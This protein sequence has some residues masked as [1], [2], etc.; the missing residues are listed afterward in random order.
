MAT[1]TA[2]TKGVGETDFATLD[3]EQ[4]GE[5]YLGAPETFSEPQ[6][7]GPVIERE[8]V[9]PEPAIIAAPEG[10]VVL[11]NIKHVNETLFIPVDG[12]ITAG[13]KVQFTDGTA[14]VSRE[15]AEFVKATL[16][17]VREEPTEGE[18]WD[19]QGFQT[20][21]RDIYEQYVRDYYEN[22]QG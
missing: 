9:S 2:R 21:S 11:R 20:R 10:K 13:N 14:I 17:H 3:D 1:T 6:G 18:I 19:F 5:L 4:I 7:E 16:P 15:Q 12:Q 8:Q 22:R